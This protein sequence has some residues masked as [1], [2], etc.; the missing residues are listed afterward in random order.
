MPRSRRECRWRQNAGALPG[1]A[2]ITA[3]AFDLC[4]PGR[5]LLKSSA[6]VKNCRD[7]VE[8]LETRLRE[9]VTAETATANRYTYRPQ[10]AGAE[11]GRRL[12]YYK[13][14][15]DHRCPGLNVTLSITPSHGHDFFWSS[16]AQSYLY[17]PVVIP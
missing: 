9:E 15:P 2:R 17:D 4:S 10:G 6:N 14:G 3:S 8:R 16:Q 1:Q 7:G 5:I 12:R 11:R 13:R